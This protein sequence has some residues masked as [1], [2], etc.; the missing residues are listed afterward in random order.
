MSVKDKG[1]YRLMKERPPSRIL[2]AAPCFAIWPCAQRPGTARDRRRPAKCISTPQLPANPR[3]CRYLAPG[4]P[5]Q[6][7]PARDTASSFPKNFIYRNL[8]KNP[9]NLSEFTDI[10]GYY[11][12][13]FSGLRLAEAVTFLLRTAPL[14]PP[15]K[16]K[17]D[18]WPSGHIPSPPS[19]VPG[20]AASRPCCHGS[21]RT[22]GESWTFGETG[23]H[24]LDVTLRKRNAPE[25]FPESFSKKFGRYT[26]RCSLLP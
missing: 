10:F 26:S 21:G 7:S 9:V 11:F 20:G 13:Y 17:D 16:P 19:G 1:L 25:G 3:I 24:R 18:G 12:L 23:P 8:S 22:R 6:N 5:W 2:A 4:G 14:P 15:E